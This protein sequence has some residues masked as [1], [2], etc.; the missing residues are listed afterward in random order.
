MKELKPSCVIAGERRKLTA[1]ARGLLLTPWEPATKVKTMVLKQVILRDEDAVQD[2]GHKGP[3][4]RPRC[5]GPRRAQTHIFSSVLRS[6]FQI[7]KCMTFKT[8]LYPLSMVT[9][10]L[11]VALFHAL[12]SDMMFNPVIFTW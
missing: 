3:V 12:D 1:K 6:K 5:I 8:P 10:L 7:L 4:L 2:L 9:S 11:A